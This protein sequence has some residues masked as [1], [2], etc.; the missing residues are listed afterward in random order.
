M[1]SSGTVSSEGET[2]YVKNGVGDEARWGT[3]N[4]LV[5]RVND[6]AGAGGIWKGVRLE[7]LKDD[8]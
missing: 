3:E 1:S 7:V 2:P 6:T 4:E 5:V 8:R